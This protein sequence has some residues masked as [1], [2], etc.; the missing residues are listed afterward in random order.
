M[1]DVDS[2]GVFDSG[3]RIVLFI[4]NWAARS[5][6]S[7]AQRAWGD[8]EVVYATR[9]RTRPGLRIPT[10]SGSEGPALTPL[11]SYSYTA[12]FEE[13]S[14][15]LRVYEPAVTDT[16]TDQFHW[17]TIGAYSIP[18]S[19]NFEINDL[20]ASQQ[21]NF[22]L[23]WQGFRREPHVHWAH[24]RN[25][26]NMVT[27]LVD[28]VAWYGRGALRVSPTI[29][30]SAVGN[31]RNVLRTWGWTDATHE[32]VLAGLNYFEVEYWRRF[33]ALRG[34]LTTR[35]SAVTGDFQVHATGFTSRAIRVYDVTD[36]LNP[37]RLTIADSLIVPSGTG[38][39]VRF[40]DQNPVGVT[41]NYVVFDTPKS[42]LTERIS[43]VERRGLSTRGS[44]DYLLVVP[45]VFLPA[46]APLDSMRR[47]Q[48]L[49]VVVAPL[50]SVNDEFNGGRHSV[51]SIRRFIR[52]GFNQWAA[53]FVMLV[54]DGSED[55]L[56]NIGFSSPDWVPVQK[57]PGP[58]G[59]F[60]M[61]SNVNEAIPSDPWYVYCLNCA[62]PPGR[63][64][65]H[66]LFIGRLP[67]NSL[68]E[69]VAVVHKLV[70]YEI[71]DP[72]DTWRR[73]MVLSA[74][75][76]YSTQTFAGNPLL[77]YCKRPYESVF[78]R[79]NETIRSVVLNEA[80]LRLSE[81]ELFDLAAYLAGVPT[82]VSGGDTCRTS[83]S[84]TQLIT[85]TTVTDKLINRLNEGRLWWNYQGHANQYVLS[86]EDLWVNR[87]SND[88]HFNLNNYDKLFFFS[89]FSCH[90]NGF[91]VVGELSPA[92]GPSLGEDLVTLPNRGAVASWGSSGFE[93]L[94]SSG[95]NHLNVRLAR[96][97]FS[98]PPRDPQLGERGA[99]VVLG[100]A[101]AVTLAR[102]VDSVSS[103]LEQ[104]VGIS[105]ILLGDPATRFSIGAAQII[106]TANG[107][108]VVD[109][110]PVRLSA[111]SD[112]LKLEADLVS[113]VELTQI[114]FERTDGSGTVV[115]P[116]D[117]YTITPAFPDTGVGGNGGRQ[118]HLS[119]QTLLGLGS[120]RYTIRTMDRYGVPGRL[121]VVFE[122]QTILLSN[123]VGLQDGD[124]VS[125]NADLALHV[126][127]P[128]R[129]TEGDFAVKVN[130]VSQTVEAEPAPSDTSGRDW[131]VR[132]DHAPYPSG[133]YVVELTV[134]G[135]IVRQ[136][137]FVVDSRVAIDNVMAFPNPFDDE[138]GTVFSFYLTGS[139]PADVLLRVF[140]VSGKLVY[141]NRVPS[142]NAA[143]AQIPWNGL[144]AEGDKLANGTYFYRLIARSEGSQV[145][146]EGKLVKLRKPRRGTPTD[147]QP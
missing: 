2:D 30:G 28:S 97:L 42:V 147:E 53:K 40:R 68:D 54:G 17:T 106:A 75:D 31:G 109:G 144:D 112:T 15:Y 142:V 84:N 63:R 99:R 116:S 6:A 88:D 20:D 98:D 1:D 47:A 34:Y 83:L 72:A 59:V 19:F 64:Q 81:P 132:W 67:V 139:G 51:Y 123:G 44:G 76:L 66:D 107:V 113:N 121:D 104:D 25:P 73:K 22:T 43:R 16:N 46:V 14:N 58:V 146:H 131:L 13:N 135:V 33:K 124:R 4:Q 39:A 120:Y 128:A 78:A 133:T 62:A 5:R 8:A 35:A 48:G 41:R 138:L 74:D 32:V 79:I 102:N 95:T 140:T 110:Q 57:V 119:Y 49:D 86:H 130:G 145:M 70:Q 55:P 50:E 12:H 56:N 3:D 114:V 45:E 18:D 134:S 136:H 10:R 61:A 23:V 117:Q 52:H 71:V 65:L 89:A 80:G 87:G 69:A 37:V 92:Q 77:G 38:Q 122:F 82:F 129:L 9:L 93:I 91:A 26:S 115:I 90:P 137:T 141:E 127:S 96:A 94:P 7:I 60:D 125:P 118:Y 105:Y 21:V 27:P 85:H 36:S 24:V 126:V 100:E 29:P 111:I 11:A 108:P 103:S 101:I 143:Y